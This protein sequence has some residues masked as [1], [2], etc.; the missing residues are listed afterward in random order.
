ML[1]EAWVRLQ[2]TWLKLEP[3]RP[4]SWPTWG[5]KAKLSAEA[6]GV[7]CHQV[8][9]LSCNWREDGGKG[10]GHGIMG[11]SQK[12]HCRNES[13]FP[14]AFLSVQVAVHL[15]A[16]CST[17]STGSSLLLSLYHHSF[18]PWLQDVISNLS[19]SSWN[20][21]SLHNFYPKHPLVSSLSW[22]RWVCEGV[23]NQQW[24]SSQPS[25]AR[26]TEAGNWWCSSALLRK[27]VF[28]TECTSALP[29]SCW[30]LAAVPGSTELFPSTL[31]N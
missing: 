24:G 10:H 4:Q 19:I 21:V 2:L 9:P 1:Q 15:S 18:P 11:S 12:L 25:A 16:R 26:E 7:F 5:V 3:S 30:D 8:S 29:F 6:V 13:H 14:L 22:G 27:G 20:L 17:N 28:F 23:T 31:P